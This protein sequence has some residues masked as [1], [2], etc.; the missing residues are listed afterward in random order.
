MLSDQLE[1]VYNEMNERLNGLRAETQEAFEGQVSMM[2]QACEEKISEYEE[3][4]K[5]GQEND[6][7]ANNALY[8]IGQLNPKF[9]FSAQ[10]E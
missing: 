5:I 7:E 4:C 3:V 10:I 2:M 8:L 6:E 9:R 1:E